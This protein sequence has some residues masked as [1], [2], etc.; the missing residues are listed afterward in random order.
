M[1]LQI[2]AASKLSHILEDTEEG[3]KDGRPVRL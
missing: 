2:N 1:D 3:F